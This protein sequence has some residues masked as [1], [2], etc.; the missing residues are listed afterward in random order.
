MT[1][2]QLVD[3]ALAKLDAALEADPGLFEYENAFGVHYKTTEIFWETNTGS[4]DQGGCWFTLRP[5]HTELPGEDGELRMFL[6]F[7]QLAVELLD[8]TLYLFANTYLGGKEHIEDILEVKQDRVVKMLDGIF[9]EIEL[10]RVAKAAEG[11]ITS[12]EQGNVTACKE[13]LSMKGVGR[14]GKRRARAN[15]K[16]QVVEGVL[17]NNQSRVDA[18]LERAGLEIN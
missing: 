15:S 18:A 12:A 4:R 17:D 9:E 7:K 10:A 14:V 3:Q 11:V 16:V 6:S 8:P 5:R 1:Y 2:T 13:I